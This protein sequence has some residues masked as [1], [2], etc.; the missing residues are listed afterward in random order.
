[1]IKILV[2][3]II[4][5]N[6]LFASI[7]TVSSLK[8]TADIKRDGK[9]IKAKRGFKINEQAQMYTPDSIQYINIY[10]VIFFY[11]KVKQLQ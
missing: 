3:F 1:M 11:P 5:I 6:T 9:T 4:T 10:N 2:L 7:A 8:G